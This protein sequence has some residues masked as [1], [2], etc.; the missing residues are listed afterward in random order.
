MELL[1]AQLWIADLPSS[2]NP[3]APP[4]MVLSASLS[5]LV[6]IFYIKRGKQDY[7]KNT[8]AAATGKFLA[9]IPGLARLS[10][11]DTTQALSVLLNF[12]ILVCPL[13]DSTGVALTRCNQS[14]QGE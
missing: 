10:A 6:G 4:N 3:R 8:K 11:F 14:Q 13:W 2:D 7:I 5:S 9:I 12:D 1:E